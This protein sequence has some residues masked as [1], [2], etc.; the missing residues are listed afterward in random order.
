MLF[1][2]EGR[3]GDF[4][5]LVHREMPA[6]WPAL[7]G[8][9]EASGYVFQAREFVVA[10][11]A[12]FGRQR[13]FTPL[14]VE[15]RDG[16][17]TPLLLLALAIERRAGIRTL[18]FLD[19]GHADYNAPLL[20]PAGRPRLADFTLDFW[21]ELLAALPPFDVARFDKMPEQLA[22]LANPMFLL[23]TGSNGASCHGT[24]LARPWPEVEKTLQRPGKLRS[25]LKALGERGE[26]RFLVA[27]D[28]AER[29]RLLDRLI[30]QKQR[31]YEETHVPGFRENPDS[32]AFLREAT[33][34]FAAS[35][36]LLLCGL[37][38]GEEIVA[39]QWGLVQGPCYYALV[40]SFEGGDWQ[41]FSCGRLLN[42]LL[43]RHLHE[44]GFAY[45]DQGVGDELYK[46][47]NCDTTVPLARSVFART[48]RGRLYLA[49]QQLMA[50][51][52][53]SAAGEQLRRL[54]WKLRRRVLGALVD[55]PEP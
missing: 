30:V 26:T 21:R 32:L 54:K 1:C 28:A 48:S 9:G 6:A 44:K 53:G 22:D 16:Q 11:Q 37:L 39:V 10:W 46:L 38:V 52:R 5:I 19:Q 36:A 17:G 15:V 40:T 34:A 27:A 35:G 13:R 33:E 50:R 25:K 14:F 24:A 20:L 7:A 12:S 4:V 51:L 31:R 23:A 29:R 3:A 49:Q 55:S 8:L 47:Q 2:P 18:T 41:R 43:L 42:Y 45:C